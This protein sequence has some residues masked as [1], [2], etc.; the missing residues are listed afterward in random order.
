MQCG[1]HWMFVCEFTMAFSYWFGAVHFDSL[2]VFYFQNY[3]TGRLTPWIMKSDQPSTV[4]LSK[5]INYEVYGPLTR[6]KLD[7]DQD[8]WPCVKEVNVLLWKKVKKG[9][10]L[11]GGKKSGL[12]ILLSSLV[13]VFSPLTKKNN[14]NNNYNFTISIIPCHGPL[15]FWYESTFLPLP[16]QNPLDHVSGSCTPLNMSFGD[17]ELYGHSNISCRCKPKWSWDKFN[18]QSHILQCL[19]MKSWSMV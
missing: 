14:D 10:L 12:T 3:T 18:N 7:V 15:L 16:H 1:S 9:Q 5:T 19:G 8:E 2:L 13:F 11:K 6:C 17:L 4:Q